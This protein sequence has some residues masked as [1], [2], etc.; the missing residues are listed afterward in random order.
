SQGQY[1][2]DGNAVEP[3]DLEAFLPKRDCGRVGDCPARLGSWVQSQLEWNTH[4]GSLNGMA[5][6]R[7]D[8]SKA[9]GSW[10]IG[11]IDVCNQ[12]FHVD[13]QNDWLT[14]CRQRNQRSPEQRDFQS[15]NRHA[16]T[17]QPGERK[18]KAEAGTKRVLCPCTR[19]KI[20]GILDS[21]PTE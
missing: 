21:M 12:V 18:N 14:M 2:P 3:Q 6:H 15:P 5:V 19:L 16:A 10:E 11:V 4:I 7:G 20:G 8:V 13:F 9:N 17:M 1:A